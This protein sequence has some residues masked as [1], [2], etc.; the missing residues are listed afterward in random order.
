MPIQ[1]LNF[2]TD[3]PFADVEPA[4]LVTL[5][6][7]LWRPHANSKL[8]GV[9]AVG[10]KLDAN[11]RHGHFQPGNTLSRG[12]GVCQS[13]QLQILQRVKMLQPVV[14]NVGVAKVERCEVFHSG[15]RLQPGIG[16]PRL[17]QPQLNQL[18]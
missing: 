9:G 18:C 11:F 16:N 17:S 15:Q 4:D 2:A 8:L 3:G 12:S 14:R 1:I 10:F 7:V 6:R 5:A 13:E